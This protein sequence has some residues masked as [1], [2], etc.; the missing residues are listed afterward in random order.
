MLGDPVFLAVLLRT[1]LTDLSR[2]V[3]HQLSLPVTMLWHAVT[4]SLYS[5]RYFLHPKV[6]ALFYKQ[7]LHS[8]FVFARHLIFLFLVFRNFLKPNRRFKVKMYSDVRDDLTR[9]NQSRTSTKRCALR[10]RKRSCS[11]CLTDGTSRRQ[12]IRPIERWHMQA[13]LT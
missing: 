11:R 1:S 7:N 4:P 9:P 5:S 8:F 13:T 3:I 2:S 12:R 10:H 6:F